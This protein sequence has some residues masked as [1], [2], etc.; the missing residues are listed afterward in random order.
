VDATAGFRGFGPMVP[1]AA[2]LAPEFMVFTYDRRGRGESTDTPPY[3]VE[4]EVE[5][6]Q[7]LIEAAGGS[8]C[9]Y[10]FSSGG[11]LALRALAIEKLALMEP[12]LELDESAPAAPDLGAGVAELVAA[13]RRGD[14]VEHFNRSIG[15]PEEMV[16]GL[17]QAPFWPALEA[18]A[19][20]LVYDTVIT[21]SAL[22]PAQLYAVT[23]PT[24][25]LASAGSDERLLGWARAVADALPNGSLRTLK[26]EW[27][28]VPPGDL[29]PVLTEF[30]DEGAPITD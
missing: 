10:G 29:A 11:V 22:A 21:S 24:L 15:V 13:G 27:H 23:T 1:L 26:G 30:F 14:A 4:R 2:A 28:G 18:L 25:V 5:D 19:H 3:A 7:A 6:L 16:A 17:R 8:A 9:V 20:T 12:P